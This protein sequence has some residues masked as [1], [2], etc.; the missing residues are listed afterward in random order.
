M[1]KQIQFFTVMLVLLG[2]TNNSWAIYESQPQKSVFDGIVEGIYSIG[3]SISEKFTE[4]DYL[5]FNTEDGFIF[6]ISENGAS[7]LCDI[8]NQYYINKTVWEMSVL[9]ENSK[10]V[11]QTQNTENAGAPTP[12]TNPEKEEPVNAM[13]I[14]ELIEE[15]GAGS[16]Y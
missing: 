14:R 2:F 13:G 15:V 6:E 5:I 10:N 11:N 12:E 16:F 1:K 8:E 7:L 3:T 4:I 9:L